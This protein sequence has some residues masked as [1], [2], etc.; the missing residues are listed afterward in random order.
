MLRY[1]YIIC[2]MLVLS[3]CVMAQSRVRINGYAEKGGKSVRTTASISYNLMETYPNC[4]VTVYI[5]GTTNLATI[6]SDSSGTAKSNPF[7]AD[8]A[9]YYFFY[10]DEGVRVDIKFSGTGILVPFTLP[11]VQAGGTGSIG[12]GGISSLNTLTDSSQVFAIGTTGTDFNISSGGGI[13]TFN[14][15]T[16]SIA[17]RGLLSSGDWAIFNLKQQLLVNSA[18]LA[19]AINDETGSDKS[20]FSLAPT[21]TNANLINPSIDNSTIGTINGLVITPTTGATLTINNGVTFTVAQSG[22]AVL[23]SRTITEG[24]GLA[25]NVYD[26]STNRTLAMGTPS[27]ITTS[28]TNSASGTTHSHAINSSSNPGASA[29]ILASNASGFLQLVRL[30][31]GVSPTQPLEVAGNIFI[32]SATANFYLKDVLTGWQSSN[33]LVVTPQNNNHIRSTTFTSGLAGWDISAAGDA[34]FNNVTVRGAIKTSV[35]LYNEI[36]ATAGTLGVFKS[37]AKL[38]TNVFVASSVT[39]GTSTVNIDIVDQ[40]GVSHAL[41]NLF[42]VN[43][44][45]R[46][47]DGLAGDTWFRISA[48]SDQTTFWRYTAVVMAGSNNVTY[49]AGMAVADYGQ[50]G[51]G[52]IIQ[53]ADQANSP[54]IQMATHLA[55]FSSNDASGTL[56]VTPQN[57]LGNLNGS[58]G[59]ASDTFGWATGTYGVAG[60]SWIIADPTNG[61]RLGSNTTSR[62]QLAADGSGFLANGN[63]SWNTSG[64]ASIAGWTINS[65]SINNSTTYVAS[66]FNPPAGA[67]A[68]FGRSAS[69]FS[70][71]ILRDSSNRAITMAVNDS[72]IFPYLNFSDGTRARIVLGG[73]N[74]AW[75]AEGS[76]SSVGMKVWDSA[77]NLL[78]HFSDVA[79]VISGWTI[80]TTKISS[81]GIDINSGASAGLAFGSTPPTSASTGTGIWLDRTGLYGLASSIL[82]AKIDATT[83]KIVAGAGVVQLGATGIDILSDN[84]ASES[85]ISWKD[86]AGNIVAQTTVIDGVANGTFGLKVS[87]PDSGAD[88]A[89]LNLDVQSAISG[90]VAIVARAANTGSFLSITGTTN[91]NGVRISTDGSTSSP[92]L[93]VA[94]EVVSTTGAFLPPKMS[95]TQRDAMV[96][97]EGMMIYNLTTHKHQGYDGTTWNDMY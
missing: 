68:W 78:I 63:I 76:T 13:H 34:E 87:G 81:T 45:I 95:T 72:T 97:I 53:T 18:G 66:S 86:A 59:F 69:G 5:V 7:I 42:V 29:A 52:F 58:Y 28:S 50:S 74:N 77:G 62:V 65:T 61:I 79:N 10:L 64:V 19:A 20:V 49:T 91:F 11:D 43:D 21:I 4:V 85:Y 17:N 46:L 35:L 71:T 40:D 75:G 56:V 88:N 51:Q 1:L 25:G 41:S 47:K 15:P 84:G 2:L 73:L 44:I 23:T 94:L 67:L 32:N 12:S 26:L 39:Y 60:K 8:A 31:I 80:G 3:T 37:A 82:Q 22:T 93:N 83:G 16:A 24:A 27:T 89:Q 57:R 70:G 54:Y 38:R 48:A 30:G 9:S 92:Q 36:Q 14:L 90:A 96:P 55:S 33:S 6:Y